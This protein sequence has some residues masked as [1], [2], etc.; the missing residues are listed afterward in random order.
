MTNLLTRKTNDLYFEIVKK[1]A[2]VTADINSALEQNVPKEEV[3]KHE[4]KRRDLYKELNIIANNI[5]LAKLGDKFN[6]F[7]KIPL[8][9]RVIDYG[10]SYTVEIPDTQLE[11]SVYACDIEEGFQ[12]DIFNHDCG[13][14]DVESFSTAKKAFDYLIKKVYELVN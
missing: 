11:I 3:K 5:H 2:L 8:V 14:C 6:N 13:D 10:T 9:L 12:V 1:M 7:S 4:L